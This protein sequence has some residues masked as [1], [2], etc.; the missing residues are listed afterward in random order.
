MCKYTFKPKS[1]MKNK[2]MYKSCCNHVRK[3]KHVQR[4]NKRIKINEITR[5]K[6]YEHYNKKAYSEKHKK[7]KTR[8]IVYI[9]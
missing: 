5:T 3:K 1:V 4:Q 2:E 8:K 7:K 9:E 6:L